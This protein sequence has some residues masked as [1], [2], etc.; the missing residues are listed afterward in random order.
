MIQ[1]SLGSRSDGDS[2]PP[3]EGGGSTPKAPRLGYSS[4][5]HRAGSEHAKYSRV[6]PAT[7]LG[8]VSAVPGPHRWSLCFGPITAAP[9]TPLGNCV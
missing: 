7:G 8:E 6:V 2:P 9:Q 3:T 5:R 1:V 4:P